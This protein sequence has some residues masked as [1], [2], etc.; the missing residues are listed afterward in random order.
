[1]KHL[2]DCID[3]LTQKEALMKTEVQDLGQRILEMTQRYEVLQRDYR[4]LQE[5]KEVLKKMIHVE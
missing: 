1:M 3:Y 4:D 2:H 5:Q